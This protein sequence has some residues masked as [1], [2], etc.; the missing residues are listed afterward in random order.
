[1][2]QKCLMLASA[3]PRKCSPGTT[4]IPEPRRKWR[5]KKKKKV[6]NHHIPETG[7]LVCGVPQA[8]KFRLAPICLARR[9]QKVVLAPVGRWRKWVGK[10]KKKA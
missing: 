6:E 5:R 4:R 8:G 1:M 3:V 9:C 7:L 2:V 10:A